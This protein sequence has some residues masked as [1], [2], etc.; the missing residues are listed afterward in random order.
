VVYTELKLDRDTDRWDSTATWAPAWNEAK[1][2]DFIAPEGI[3][4][5]ADQMRDKGWCHCADDSDL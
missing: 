3:R 1:R 4:T 5:Q 2:L